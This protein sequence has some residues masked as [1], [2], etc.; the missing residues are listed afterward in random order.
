M[1]AVSDFVKSVRN[2][3][4]VAPTLLGVWGRGE[5]GMQQSKAGYVASL[6]LQ[7]RALLGGIA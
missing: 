7:A 6:R 5:G 3:T 4:N 2:P 1:T